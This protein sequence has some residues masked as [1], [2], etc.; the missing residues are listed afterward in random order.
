MLSGQQK[1]L[2]TSL[3]THFWSL[4]AK[5]GTQAQSRVPEDPAC[6]RATK[7]SQGNCRASAL[8][9]SLCN[10]GSG[11]TSSPL[12][13]IR[14]QPAPAAAKTQHSRR[15][16]ANQEEKAPLIALS[17][18]EIVLSCLLG[19]FIQSLGRPGI[20]SSSIYLLQSYVMRLCAR[21]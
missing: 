5:A 1:R 3:V 9:D 14:E 10:K 6:L 2:I 15:E 18:A 20:Q 11:P 4:P 12:A 13:T 16:S 21:W 19:W 8:E 7:P 17:T